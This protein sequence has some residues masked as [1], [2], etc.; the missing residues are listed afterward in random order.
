MGFVPKTGLVS[1]SEIFRGEEVTTK[2]EG[3]IYIYIYIYI[4]YMYR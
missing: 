4:Y 1:L 2:S 3:C